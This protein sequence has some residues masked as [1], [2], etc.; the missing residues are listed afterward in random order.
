MT[1]WV[2]QS[3]P[4]WMPVDD[5]FKKAYVDDWV[6]HVTDTSDLILPEDQGDLIP[7]TPRVTLPV[8]SS[9]REAPKV[10]ASTQEHNEAPLLPLPSRPTRERLELPFSYDDILSGFD[11][12][13]LPPSD[14]FT[15]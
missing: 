4:F 6:F 15:M 1:G 5:S 10:Y 13:R 8:T 12:H 9:Y 14:Q 2:C 11:D 3:K 7:E